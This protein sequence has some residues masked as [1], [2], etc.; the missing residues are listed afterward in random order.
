MV[1][2]LCY[3]E[4]GGTYMKILITNVL[5]KASYRD[6]FNRKIES[7]FNPLD[8][9]STTV[10]IENLNAIKGIDAYSHLIISG[11]EASVL[12]EEPWYDALDT[13]LQSFAH[14]NKPVLGI[15]FGHQ[16]IAKSYCG[17]LA[18]RK[19]QQPE[20]GWTDILLE[21]DALF[22]DL[23]SFKSLV[24][25]YDE[26]K[27]LDDRFEIIAQSRY[28]PIHGFKMKAKPIWGVQ[29]HP[30]FLY[31][32]VAGILE[33]IEKTDPDF[34]QNHVKTFINED[35]YAENNKIF[36]NFVNQS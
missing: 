27:E 4:D 16:F 20:F 13:V 5:K 3:D 2:A 32:D 34:P 9:Q 31:A 30:D 28:C 1:G 11:S 18:V 12:E 17:D 26:V 8:I 15:C 33:H 6:A 19:A 7:V 35:I 36:I 23:K 14:A 25:H 21:K 29:F 24:L 10:Y 22:K